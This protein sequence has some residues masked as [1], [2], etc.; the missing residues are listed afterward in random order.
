MKIVNQ[1]LLQ[2]AEELAR[3]YGYIETEHEVKDLMKDDFWGTSYC[4]AKRYLETKEEQTFEVVKYVKPIFE[5]DID[6]DKSRPRIELRVRFNNPRIG[7]YLPE[8]GYVGLEYKPD[9][10]FAEAQIF[11]DN[12]YYA[13]PVI[14][15]MIEK[16]IQER[17][18][19]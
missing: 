18:S 3:K 14:K 12:G 7:I 2:V 19:L 4:A 16:S 6:P 8:G 5:D 1:A 9:G 17:R 10:T 15:E 11:D 13:I